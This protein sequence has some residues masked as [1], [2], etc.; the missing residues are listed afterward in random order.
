MEKAMG[1]A[2]VTNVVAQRYAKA[3]FRAFESV[4]DAEKIDR[5]HKL[6]N[7]LLKNKEIFVLLNLPS[8]SLEDKKGALERICDRFDVPAVVKNLIDPLF[9][10]H[11]IELFDHIL[12]LFVVLFKRKHQI[13]SYVI[14]L[15]GSPTEQDKQEILKALDHVF[16]GSI[17]AEFVVDSTLISGM[18]IQGDSVLW[19]SSVRKNLRALE[20]ALLQRVQLC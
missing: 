12:C 18:R 15:S 4:F 7:Y 17:V 5:T 9:K 10:R 14:Y 20:T 2:C 11:C 1:D 8:I 3:F 6:A 16:G 19:E 13:K